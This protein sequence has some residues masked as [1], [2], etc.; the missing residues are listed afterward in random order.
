M[1]SGCHAYT[2]VISFYSDARVE[3]V[4]NQVPVRVVREVGA[5]VAGHESRMHA[6][7]ADKVVREEEVPGPHDEESARGGVTAFTRRYRKEQRNTSCGRS[8]VRVGVGGGLEARD[9][10]PS[11]RESQS[12]P[13]FFTWTQSVKD[14][15]G[16][17][18]GESVGAGDEQ[19]RVT[20]SGRRAH[21]M[22]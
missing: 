19:E 15:G 14:M 21:I 11:R 3:K 10:M 9:W 16:G 2:T 6:D 4:L 22:P 8:F 13:S 1:G 12:L 18:D 20:M 7:I 17:N 5:V